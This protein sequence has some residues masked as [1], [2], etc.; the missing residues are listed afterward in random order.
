MPLY[1]YLTRI[2]SGYPWGFYQMRIATFL[3]R[4]DICHP[5]LTLQNSISQI[6]LK[7]NAMMT[8]LDG[9]EEL[10]IH[11]SPALKTSPMSS[12]SSPAPSGANAAQAFYYEFK[13]EF[14]GT[15]PVLA[16]C[17]L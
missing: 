5:Y 15:L 11:T 6:S 10:V 9:T 14:D 16:Y 17:L 3:F 2:P 13:A 7:S 8:P 12:R 4:V 1:S